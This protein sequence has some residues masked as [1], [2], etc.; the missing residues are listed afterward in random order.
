[1]LGAVHTAQHWHPQHICQEGGKV[2]ETTAQLWNGQS[3]LLE[4]RE[5]GKTQ[6]SVED[7]GRNMKALPRDAVSAKFSSITSQYRKLCPIKEP[8]LLLGEVNGHIFKGHT[9]LP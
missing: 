7:T 9:G 5:D 1:M 4:R 3:C 6:R 2:A 8:P